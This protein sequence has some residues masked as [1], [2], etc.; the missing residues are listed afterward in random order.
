[1]RRLFMFAALGAAVLGLSSVSVRAQTSFPSHTITMVVPYPAGGSVDG[2]ARILAQALHNSLGQPVIVENRAG[3]AG[4]IV[5][6]NT[7][8]K[9]SPDGY[10]LL[11]TASI[12]VVTPFLHKKVPYDVVKDFTPI[13]LVAAGPLVV[14]TSPKVPANNLKELFELVRK[15]PDKY[16]FATSGFGSAGHLA[17]ELLKRDAGVNTLVIAYKGAGPALTDL[18]SGQIQLMVDP[19]LSSM[20][21]ARAGSIKALAITSTKRVAV[22]PEIPTLAESGMQGFD[23]ASWYGLWGPKDMPAA[24]VSKLQAEVA[25]VVSQQDVKERLAVLGFESIGSTSEYFTK[26][27]ADEMTKYDQIIK[28]S[29][30]KAE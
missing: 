1:M 29:N 16:T 11:L 17:I 19:M 27:I 8:A 23:F 24:V 4:G 2:V 22:A 25:K 5:G 14:S 3:G 26:Y 13:S 6:A 12:H 21:L 9:S 20:P 10:T 30:I 15:E 28:A 7:V 18:M